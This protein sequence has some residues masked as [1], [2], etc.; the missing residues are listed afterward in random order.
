[1][2]RSLLHEREHDC[3]HGLLLAPLDRGT[4]YLA[5]TTAN[6]LFMVAAELFLVPLSSSSS[7]CRSDP[8]V[9]PPGPGAPP[10]HCSASPPSARSSPPSSLRTRAREVDAA[11]AD[12]AARHAAAHR[13]HP[14]RAPPLL[15]GK[16]VGDRRHWL[17][18]LAAF[19]VVFLVVGWLAFEYV[20]EE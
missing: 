20:V 6:F 16:P 3:L 9:R 19:D 18:L 12:A 7:T 15:A 11:A 13:Q 1:M 17:R 8:H 14:G 2:N 5:K 4:I 10:R